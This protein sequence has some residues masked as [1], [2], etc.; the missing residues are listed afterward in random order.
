L[1]IRRS[2]DRHDLGARLAGHC[3]RDRRADRL[4]GLPH[5][6]IGKVRVTLRRRG[7]GMPKNLADDWQT[8]AA[9]RAD[10]R[11]AMTKIMDAQPVEP[12]GFPDNRPWPV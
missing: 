2:L 9:A 10:R 7:L 12:G 8:E 6:I 11:E 4:D 3:R 5:R 1:R